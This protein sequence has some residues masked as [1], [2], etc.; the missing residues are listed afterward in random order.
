MYSCS[1]PP[2]TVRKSPRAKRAKLK[3]TPL[4]EV[5]VVVPRGFDSSLIPVLLGEHQ[6]WLI[7]TLADIEKQRRR[8]HGENDLLPRKIALPAIDKYVSVMYQ[9]ALDSQLEV[10]KQGTA[11]SLL[12]VMGP[13]EVEARALLCSWFQ[14]LAQVQLVQILGNL[15][16]QMGL[17]FRKMSVRAQKSRWGSCSSQRNIS[18]NRSVLFLPKVLMHYVLVHELCHTRHLNHSRE[19]WKLVKVHEPDYHR[20]DKALR[21]GWNY[22]P[23]WAYPR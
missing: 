19:Y 13:G 11:N 8:Y 20:L 2:Y 12:K 23:R 7:S 22:V 5:E 14:D 16:D 10:E 4:G 3:I 1:L 21:Q 9:S 6:H 18:I 17:P 15:S